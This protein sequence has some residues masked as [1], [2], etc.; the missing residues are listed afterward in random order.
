M[1]VTVARKTPGVYVTELDAFP[2]SVV[3]VQ[4]ALPAFIGYTQTAEINGKPVYNQPIKITSLADY[5][6]IFGI[7]F[8]PKYDIEEVTDAVKIQEGSF[9]FK[10]SDP[11]DSGNLKY[12]NLVQTG[13][14]QFNLF[15]SM[16]LFY[17]NGGGTCYIVSVGDYTASGATPD[18]VPIDKAKLEAGL[19]AIKDQSGPTM[20]VV[21]DAV[22]LA[23]SGGEEAPWESSDFQSITRQ[24]LLQS[25]E[26]Q[27][28]VAI[29]DVYG[30]QYADKNNLDKIVTQ[31]QTDVGDNG[32]SYGMGYFPFL[33]TTVV[34]VSD[35]NY[36]NISDAGLPTLQQVLGW[37]NAN[38]NNGG[39]VPADGE[40]TAR[41]IAVKAY[42]DAM[43]TTVNTATDPNAV[44]T[45]NQNL[46]AAL[47]LLS[48]ILL[49][50]VEKNDILPPSGAMAGI[51]T[52]V[53]TNSG[54]WN[55]PANVAL[56]SVSEPTFKLT[57][58]QQGDLNVPINGKAI[59]AIREFTGRGTVVWGARTLDGNSNDWRYIQVRRTLIYIEQ[60]IKNAIDPFVFAANDAN[61]WVKVT[62]MVS[63]FLQGLWSQ[64][65]LMGDTA[66]DAFTVQCGLGSTM[67]G[68]DVLDGYMIVQVTV[69]MIRPAE[70][71]E[72]TFKQTMEG[73]S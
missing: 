41:Y 12:Y 63:S 7:G 29:L 23:S 3:G 65:G 36:Q 37:E 52:A 14:S 21:P 73:V 22:L 24:M 25:L 17:D 49:V 58:E 42:I 48:N 64:G 6:E 71:I 11:S 45:L 16:R 60:S 54:V 46:T 33:N 4:T 31:F 1:P 32:L 13:S 35:F 43:P 26:L 28:R 44:N 50:I 40:G 47:P 18:G 72:L 53:D 62:A 67:T 15:N 59:D 34:P 20:L 56:S 57:D 69:Q 51:Y 8:Q 30:S 38:L 9:D 61:T 55:A 66:S 27:D 5:T 10:V 19:D 68:Q 2:P 70:F 39:V